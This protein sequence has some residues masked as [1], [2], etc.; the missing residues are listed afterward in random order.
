MGH[1]PLALADITA[2]EPARESVPIYRQWAHGREHVTFIEAAA[3]TADGTMRFADG[4]GG[5]SH[6]ATE[7]AGI[8]VPAVDVYPHLRDADF[9]KIDIEGGEW[10][11]LADPRLADLDDLVLVMEYHRSPGAVAARGGRRA[12]PAGA[13]RFHRRP[14][15]CQ[16]L[17][18]RHV[19][20]LEGRPPQ[21]ITAR[22]AGRG[23]P[24]VSG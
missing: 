19:V 18:P 3:A 15:H 23:L 11:I 14:R 10:P 8:E 5:G 20:G 1:R 24:R 7:G 9:V 2:F 6:V 21:G 22:P 12:R 17:G 4:F 13:G 16:L